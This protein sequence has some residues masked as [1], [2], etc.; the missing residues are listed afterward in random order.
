MIRLPDGLSLNTALVNVRSEL[1]DKPPAE[2]I[3]ELNSARKALAKGK[4]ARADRC[5]SAVLAT[6]SESGAGWDPSSARGIGPLSSVQAA[7]MAIRGRVAQALFRPGAE[8]LLQSAVMIWERLLETGAELE[9]TARAEFL[10]ALLLIEQGEHAARFLRQML[11]QHV[12]VPVDAILMVAKWVEARDRQAAVDL[13]ASVLRRMS[14]EPDLA[15]S[16]AAVLE[17]AGRYRDASTIHVEAAVLFFGQGDQEA[18]ERHMRQALV[19]D[20]LSIPALCGLARVLLIQN[21]AQE[22]LDALESAGT[23]TSTDLIVVRA[24]ALWD[25][26]R[27]D[28]AYELVVGGLVEYPTSVDLSVLRAQLDLEM[29]NHEAALGQLRELLDRRPD[30]PEIRLLA[31]RALIAQARAE[32]ALDILVTLGDEFPDSALI[33]ALMADAEASLGREDQALSSMLEALGADPSNPEILRIRD[34]LAERWITAANGH[35][36]ESTNVQVRA[37]LESAL[38]IAPEDPRAHAMMGEFLRLRGDLE[39]ALAHLTDAVRI[40][41]G[42]AWA[43]GTLGQ[44]QAALDLPEAVDTLVR[45]SEL[46]DSLYWIHVELADAYRLRGRLAEALRE[47]DHAIELDVEQPWSWAIKGS[48]Q[49]LIDDWEGARFAL[50]HAVDLH[51]A[52]AWA[53]AVKANLHFWIAERSVA[54]HAALQ[55]LRLDESLAWVWS[56]RAA[57]IEY[58]GGSVDVQQDAARRAVENEP[59]NMQFRMNYGDALLRC[60]DPVGAGAEFR[61]A[62]RIFDGLPAPVID[63]DA[64]ENVGWCKLRLKDAEG[65]LEHLGIAI[66]RD[67]R[68]I[69]LMFDLGLILMCQGRWQ[70]SY[71]EYRSGI[72]RLDSESH[73]G[74]RRAV[75]E[76]ALHNIKQ[77]CAQGI[78]D[79]VDEHVEAVIALLTSAAQESPALVPEPAGASR[80]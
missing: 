11:D 14:D 2:L 42:S 35:L 69:D 52:Y 27:V 4:F 8:E 57:L 12:E 46:D 34:R 50:D 63:V 71:A 67:A 64:Q 28:D 29:R 13:L 41:P 32:E 61:E 25:L 45:A 55:A 53:W 76:M 54:D 37:M 23:D 7:A 38:A 16:L 73:G 74:R 80:E 5:A 44:V 17:R 62:I 6:I 31:A 56:M 1:I 21:R 72:S 15:V 40:N 20:P 19:D 39:P 36:T 43:M 33:P 9:P 24:Y 48:I 78:L 75:L 58:L 22:A 68:R 51:P 77:L 79:V 47:I 26:G 18:A 30:D 10:G 49:L 3:V 65:A 70:R 60:G 66:S 59:E